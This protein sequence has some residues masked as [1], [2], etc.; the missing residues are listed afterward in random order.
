LR[1]IINLELMKNGR[2]YAGFF[3]GEEDDGERGGGKVHVHDEVVRA[4]EFSHHQG[5]H[6]QTKMKQV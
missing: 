1:G 3:E 5:N 4:D 2:W 6:H